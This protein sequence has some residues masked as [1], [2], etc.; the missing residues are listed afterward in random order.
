[1]S[2]DYT[3]GK[4]GRKFPLAEER[5]CR[6]CGATFR[7]R[8]QDA[9]AGRGIYCSMLCARRGSAASRGERRALEFWT[10][11]VI[12]DSGC[13]E[14]TASRNDS[15]YGIFSARGTKRFAHRVAYT[16][17]VGQIPKG[18]CVCHKCDNP[19][20][21]NPEHLFLGTIADN[22]ADMAAKGRSPRGERN[23][24]ARLT[25]D[26]VRNIRADR[27]HGTEIAASFGVST[28]LVSLIRARKVWSHVD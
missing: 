21:I 26:L 28:A 10:N 20:C 1:M 4:G 6:H 11:I 15:G 9:N 7:P 12:S 3:I 18:M 19:P 17:A 16:K 24:A 5:S 14:W 2:V 22:N 23:W 13:H 8:Q 25:A 27:R